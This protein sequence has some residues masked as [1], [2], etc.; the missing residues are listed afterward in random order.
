MRYTYFTWQHTQKLHRVKTTAHT[1]IQTYENINEWR[2]LDGF[3]FLIWLCYFSATDSV[4]HYKLIFFN[5]LFVGKFW[6][7]IG[8]GPLKGRY[9]QLEIL[10]LRNW[11]KYDH[12][13]SQIG[14]R[15]SFQFMGRSTSLTPKIPL[16][17][18]RML[19]PNVQ[20]DCNWQV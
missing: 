14:N 9:Y 4:I 16:K 18:S 13:L 2:S 1:S 3:G 20:I 6:Q 12:L 19:W 15:N 11:L 10:D 8:L 5:F 7:N 17:L